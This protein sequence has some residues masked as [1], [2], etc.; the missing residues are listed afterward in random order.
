MVKLKKIKLTRLET[1]ELQEREMKNLVGGQTCGCGC[2]YDGTSGGATSA[3][4]ARANAQY[5]YSSYGGSFT[6]SYFKP[7]GDHV[8]TAVVN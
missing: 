4:N 2:H 3:D 1:S 5:G 8:S 7:N 6:C